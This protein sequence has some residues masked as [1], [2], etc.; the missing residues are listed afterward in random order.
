[1]AADLLR[2]CPPSSQAQLL[3]LLRQAC[4]SAETHAG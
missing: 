4:D 1:V 3:A 2:D